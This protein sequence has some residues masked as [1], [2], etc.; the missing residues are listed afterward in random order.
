[1]QSYL[2]TERLRPADA[3]AVNS[4]FWVCVIIKVGILAPAGRA[5]G[6]RRFVLLV[7]SLESLIIVKYDYQIHIP[8]GDVVFYVDC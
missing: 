4:D 7:V 3:P 5:V 2:L 6:Q 8:F 1:M